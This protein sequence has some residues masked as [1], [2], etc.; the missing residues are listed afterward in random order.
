MSKGSSAVR[1]APISVPINIVPIVSI[2]IE[3]TTGTR[4]F[5]SA[6]Y[7]KIAASADFLQQV[8]TCLN[9]QQVGASFDKSRG[10][11]VIG[12]AHFGKR[13]MSERRELRRRAYRTGNEPR[14]RGR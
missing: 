10:L 11:F 13:D 3:A 12:L 9:N 7:L 1:A 5:L 8:L 14:M 2:V 4:S 6:K